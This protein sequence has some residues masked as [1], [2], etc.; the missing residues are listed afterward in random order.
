[1]ATPFV[2]IDLSDEARDFRPFALEPG[3]PMLDRSNANAKILFRWLGRLVAEPEW[4]G[5][6]V[7]FYVCD[8]RGGRLE[9]VVCQPASDADLKNSLKDDL[10]TLQDRIE[11]AKPET[12]TERAVKRMARRSFQQLMD[13]PH[14]TDLDCYFFRYRDVQ[15]RGRLVWCWGYQRLDQE[16]APAAVCTRPE[17]SLLFVR[18][19][20]QSPKCPCCEAGLV[21][22]PRKKVSGK[23]AALLALLLLLLAAVVLYGLFGP[24]GLKVTPERLDMVVGEIADLVVVVELP[25]DAPVQITSPDPAVVEITPDNRL[26]ARGEGALRVKVTRANRSCT[27]RVTVSAAEFQS[28]AVDPARLVVAVDDSVRPRVVARIAGDQS[29]RQVEIA[30]DLLTCQQRPSP[31]Y[32]EFDPPSMR[33]R[34]L[35]P[36]DAT[37]P[38]ELAFLFQGLRGSAPVEVVL[39]RFELTLEPPGPVDLPLGQQIQLEGFATSEEGRRVQVPASRLT[40]E[41][42][43]TPDAVPGLELRGNKVA[44]LKLGAG[45]LSVSARYFDRQS[46]PVVFRSVEAVAV[47]LQLKADRTR[48][49]AGETGKATLSATSPQGEVELVPDL[50]EYRSSDPA[51]LKIDERTGAFRAAAPGEVT[52]TASHPAGGGSATVKLA[53]SQPPAE[54]RPEAVRILTDQDQPVRFPVGAAFDDFHVE[55]EYADGITRLV[56]KKATLRTPQE[57]KEAVVTP[58]EGRLVGVRPGRT[59]V[60]AEFEGVRSEK[61]LEAEVTAT[62]DVDRISIVPAPLTILRGETV[63]LDVV[64]Y[65]DGKSVGLITGLGNLVWSSSDPE[66]ARVEGHS[67]TGVNLG[68]GSVT[69]QLGELLSQPAPLS[70]V[71]SSAAGS[72]AKRWSLLPD[73]QL[74]RI[75][76][77]QA[78]RI[79]TDLSISRGDLDVSRQCTVSPAL[80]GVVRYLP[81]LDSLL[82]VAPGASAVA[83]TYGDKLANVM[84]EVLPAVPRI[85]G[86]VIVEPSR[87]M[88]APGQAVD[89]RVLV[90]AAMP[91]RLVGMPP[92]APERIDRT[93]SAALN[94]SDSKTLMILGSRACALRAGTSEITA[95]LPGTQSVGRAYLVVGNDEIGQL[96]VEPPQAAI[97]TGD[98]LRLRIL[99]T[100]PNGTYEMFPQPDL[101]LTPA[102]PNREAIQILGPSDV[103]GV[104]A[105]QAAVVVNWRNRL[106]RQVPI[107]VTDDLLTDLRIEPASAVIHPGQPLVYQVTAMR[108]GRRRVLGPEH[109]VQLFVDNQAVAQVIDR[110]AVRANSPGRTLVIASVGGRQAQ[111]SLEV[112]AGG[113]GYIEGVDHAP[114]A[115]VVGLRFDPDLLRLSPGSRPAPVRVFELLADGRLGR[116]VTAEPNLKISEPQPPGIV[117]LEKTPN[118]LLLRPVGPGQLWLGTRLGDL[119]ADPLLVQVGPVVPGLARL[120]VAPDPLTLWSGETGTFGSVM[121]DPGAGQLPFAADYKIAPAANQRIVSSAGD[122]AIRALSDGSTQVVVTAV[123]P[124]GRY[125]GLSTTATVQ[126]ISA[127]PL[128]IEP[129]TIPLSPGQA[130]PPLAVMAQGQDGLSYQVPAALESMDPTVLTPDPAV[131]GGFVA[132]GL[133]GTQIRASYRGRQGFAEVAVSGQRFVDVHEVPDSL[134]G[135]AQSFYI[136]L[137]VL[138]AAS[139]GPL[140]YRVYAPAQPAPENWVAAEPRDEHLQAVL[141]S[142]RVPYGP[143]G[144]VYHLIVEA[145]SPS[146]GSVQRYPFSFRLKEQVE[147]AEDGQRTGEEG[148]GKGEGTGGLIPPR[149]PRPPSLGPGP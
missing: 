53:V 146:D 12:A 149:F 113:P 77:G 87:A 82:G 99:G 15:G 138:A 83:F 130:T 37:S 57:P 90:V 97:S 20:K 30:P 123:D 116:E 141:R 40:F 94:S 134:A 54:D 84:V 31:R 13:D 81:Q 23:K 5:D 131:P 101:T 16:P 86:E 2:R 67:V 61:P 47:T 21:P 85:D 96:I 8:D 125:E 122:Q 80:P 9:E 18:R 98:V 60:T 114:P 148:R 41:S 42:Q 4:E 110:L 27:V 119:I 108:G 22:R 115:D 24:K 35:L 74:I 124:G 32:A 89:L 52:I 17:C 44:A 50:A 129:S 147:R 10:A 19:P 69:A 135:D 49:L 132:Q 139:E 127:D 103:R 7:S 78:V 63:P 66:I 93:A 36:T 112:V 117:T 100:A 137:E 109:G 107:Q 26:I 118:G 145:R 92:E 106:S 39:G 70:V 56:T 6:L 34:G 43:S 65:K 48:Y 11:Q 88:L 64:G 45:P 33:L 133:G 91:T 72:D 126:V 136:R 1:M 143:R 142:P 58:S 128:R 46:P 38:Q 104:Q 3:V 71:S 25:S 73:Q 51:V 59:V 29:D 95:T 111:A 62:L 55:A 76:V 120:L 14:R 140:E 28:I 79:G 105:G 68:Q 75:R 102:G 121:V 144:S